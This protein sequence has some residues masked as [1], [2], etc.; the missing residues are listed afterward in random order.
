VKG[1][2]VNPYHEMPLEIVAFHE[3]GHAKQFIERPAVFADE[4]HG[5]LHGSLREI[6]AI[7]ADFIAHRMAG[8]GA[9]NFIKD[10]KDAKVNSSA[11]RVEALQAEFHQKYSPQLREDY[12]KRYAP[13][14]VERVTGA[15]HAL[16]EMDNIS[17]HEQPVCRE[18]KIPV[19]NNYRG[20][21]GVA[22]LP[23]GY[24]KADAK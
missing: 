1:I 8:G 17:R 18:A 20:F 7:A 5:P 2:K 12:R 15:W 24:F 13:D 4:A 9:R 3:L 22:Q 10:R 23:R 6:E 14:K 21:A 16:L 11:S 19:R